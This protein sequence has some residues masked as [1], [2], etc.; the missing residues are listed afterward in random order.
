MLSS[1]G[2]LIQQS[3][4]PSAMVTVF[5]KVSSLLSAHLQTQWEVAQIWTNREKACSALAWLQ[6]TFIFPL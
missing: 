3:T 6:R 1:F 4:A 2:I 5:I